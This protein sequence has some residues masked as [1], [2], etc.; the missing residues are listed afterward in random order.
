[1][2]ADGTVDLLRAVSM[3]PGGLWTAAGYLRAGDKLDS[4]TGQ[5]L[6][7]VSVEV[8]SVEVDTAATRVYNFEVAEDHTYAVGELQA[9]VHNATRVYK[10]FERISTRR[11][12]QAWENYYGKKWPAGHDCH[13][14]VALAD[15]GTNHPS[16]FIPLT[17]QAHRDLHM[18]NNDFT[19]WATK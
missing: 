1:L 7:V 11:M 19:R 16:N 4:A 13:H 14:I 8:V 15:R 12:R 5:P 9:W 17:P 10:M 3:D 2:R 6:E 18:K